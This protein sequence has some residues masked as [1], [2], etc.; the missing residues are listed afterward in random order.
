MLS[1]RGFFLGAG[2]TAFAIV[3]PEILMPIKSFEI[4]DPVFSTPFIGT[5]QTIGWIIRRSK[6]SP[7]MLQTITHQNGVECHSTIQ[8]LI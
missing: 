5:V 2:A 7:W 4:P 3:K 1:R 8:Q 6:N